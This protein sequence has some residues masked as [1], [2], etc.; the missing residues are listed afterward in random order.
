MGG[1]EVTAGVSSEKRPLARRELYCASVRNAP[2]MRSCSNYSVFYADFFDL[3]DAPVEF[4]SLRQGFSDSG[5]V[6]L[7]R[8]PTFSIAGNT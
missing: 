5:Q 6:L 3:D 4:Y 8:A 2:L 7:M 1:L